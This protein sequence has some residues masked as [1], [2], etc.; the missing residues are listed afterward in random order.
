M[1]LA[2]KTDVAAVIVVFERDGKIIP[3]GRFYLPQTAIDGSRHAAY[4]GWAAKG[5]LIPTP[6]DIIDFSMIEADLMGFT[7]RFQVRNI[8]YDPWQ[9]TQLATRLKDQGASM[10]EFRQTVANFSEPTKELDG[11]MRSGKIAHDGNPAL[12]WMI[13][14]VVGHYDAKD[15]LPAQGASRKQDRWSGRTHH[16]HRATSSSRRERKAG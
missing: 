8:G 3:F 12:N 1:D 15:N 11:L 6:G 16:G 5:W 14:N 10:I 2:S 7:S 4:R 13:G 9:A